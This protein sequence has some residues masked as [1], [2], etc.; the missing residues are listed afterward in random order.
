MRLMK[1]S[2]A[3]SVIFGFFAVANAAPPPEAQAIYDRG[4]ELF[5]AGDYLTAGATFE[6]AYHRYPLASFLVQRRGD[7]S[8]R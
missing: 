7:L 2:V 5:S 1:L 3:W 4:R 6:E 8:T